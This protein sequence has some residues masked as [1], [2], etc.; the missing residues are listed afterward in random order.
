MHRNGITIE[1][2][3]SIYLV[4]YKVSEHAAQD[5]RSVVIPH[6]PRAQHCRK[7]MILV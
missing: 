4:Q 7:L 5:F 3:I 6:F 1:N 2:S